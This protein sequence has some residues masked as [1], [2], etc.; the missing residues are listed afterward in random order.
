MVDRGLNVRQTEALAAQKPRDPAA[1]PIQAPETAALERD[2]SGAARAEVS[3]RHAGRGGQ[4]SIAYRDLDQLD[5]LIR[6]L[7]Q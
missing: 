4:V 7:Q 2:L 3:I 5:G 6:L 1:K